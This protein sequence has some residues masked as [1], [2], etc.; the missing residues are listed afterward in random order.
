VDLFLEEY[1]TENGYELV[2]LRID[3]DMIKSKQG[4]R[5]Y[6]TSAVHEKLQ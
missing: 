2:N 1:F 5:E 4:I 3:L 6:V